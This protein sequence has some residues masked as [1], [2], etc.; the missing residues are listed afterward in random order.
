MARVREGNPDVP[1]AGSE[2]LAEYD[3]Y[4]YAQDRT[5]PLPVLRVKFGD[6]DAT[7]FYIDPGMSQAVA[8]FTRRQRLQRWIYHGFH[9]LDFG[10][11]YSSR[12]LWDI[13]IIVLSLGGTMLSVIGV[14]IGYRRLKKMKIKKL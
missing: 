5:A 6:P 4:Y 3:S 10:F 14:V 11:W 7:W 12:P 9:S 13:G 1:I 2:I 8:S